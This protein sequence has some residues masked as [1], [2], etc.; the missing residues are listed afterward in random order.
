MSELKFTRF[1]FCHLNYGCLLLSRRWDSNPQPTDYKSVAQPVVLHRHN[2]MTNLDLAGST[3][4][5]ALLDYSTLRWCHHW[6]LLSPRSKQSH[7][8][9]FFYSHFV[10][11]G[12][13]RTHSGVSQRIYSPPQLSNSS[14]PRNS[15]STLDPVLYEL[16]TVFGPVDPSG[17]EPPPIKDGIYSPA[18]VSERLLVPKYRMSFLRN[19]IKS[20][21]VKKFAEFILCY[22]GRGRTYIGALATSAFKAP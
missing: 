12:G 10:G 21:V 13:I 3:Q 6:Q 15:N 17:L 19:Q 9:T 8:S 5:N 16:V 1:V 4:P 7:S 22:P 2:K 18:A 14:A 20:L 11:G